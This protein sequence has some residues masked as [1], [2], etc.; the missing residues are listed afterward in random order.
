VAFYAIVDPLALE[1][2]VSQH[3][4]AMD[5]KVEYP[6]PLSPSMERR[7]TSLKIVAAAR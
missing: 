6:A 3:I 1:Q 7:A 5:E 2:A 4:E